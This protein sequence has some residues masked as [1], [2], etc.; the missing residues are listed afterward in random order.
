[1]KQY[2]VIFHLDEYNGVQITTLLKNIE[3]LITDLG[4][5][6][7]QIEVVANA[8]GVNALLKRPN[9]HTDQ[10]VKLADKGVYFTACA[11]A[12]HQIGLTKDKLLEPVDIVRSGIGELVKRQTQGWVYIRP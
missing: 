2:R 11:I 5:N 8:E 3:N 1:M 4:E 9:S 12:I 6:N 10:I 7:V